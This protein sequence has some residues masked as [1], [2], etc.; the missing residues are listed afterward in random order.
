MSRMYEHASVAVLD[1]Q[2]K[3]LGHRILG[4]L[5]E[6]E[7]VI[8]ELNRR[9]MNYRALIGLRVMVQKVAARLG[10]PMPDVDAI[11]NRTRDET[12]YWVNDQSMA[13]IVRAF[14]P[15]KED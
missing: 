12:A 13:E 6:R 7:D 4:L 14:L 11:P 1:R 15:K 9:G 2:V 8:D 3:D 10:V 5:R